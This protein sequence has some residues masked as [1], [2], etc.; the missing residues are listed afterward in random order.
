MQ[1]PIPLK[2]LSVVIPIYNEEQSIEEVL[3]QIS[4]VNLPGISKEIILSD[5]ASTDNTAQIL[6]RY[7][8]NTTEII[9][10]HTSP[11]NLGKG[12]AVRLGIAYATGDIIIIQDADL[13]LNPQEYAQVIQPI[14]SGKTDVAYGSR[15]L[16]ESNLIPKRTRLANWFLTILT[17]VLFGAQL[18]DMETAYKAFRREV[19]SNIKLR[20]VRFDFEPEITAKFLQ[21]GYKIYEVPISYR[22]RT[23]EEGKKIS[24]ID[25]IEA[26]YTLLRCR[27]FDKT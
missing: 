15:F 14:L 4:N 23:T 21:A 2:K 19:F 9:K 25:G 7:I 8:Q 20:C 27:F 22:P 17:N 1:D 12:A 26:I 24:W 6:Q 10:V 16:N 11:V 5:D 13:E 18:T 3:Q